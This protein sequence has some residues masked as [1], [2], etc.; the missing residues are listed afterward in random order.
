MHWWTSFF[1]DTYATIGLETESEAAELKRTKV[2]ELIDEKLKLSSG[3][4]V[5]D[6]CCGIGRLSVPLARRGLR[7]IGVDQAARYVDVARER[8]AGFDCEFYAGDAFDFVAPR[9]CDGAINWFT[10]FGYHRDDRVNIR[11]LQRAHDSLRSGGRFLLEYISLPKL[12]AEF[13]SSIVDRMQRADGEHMLIQ[14]PAIDFRTGML[15]ATWTFLRPDGS[16][17][18]RRTENRAYMPADLLHL[19]EQAGF[20]EIELLGADGLPFDRTSRRCLTLGRKP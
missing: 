17:E 14:E 15:S 20:I 6:Q 8:T 12:L 5:F 7:V 11:M 13:K 1:D 2:A 3:D 4:T 18:S 9:A 19:F 10:S 16:R